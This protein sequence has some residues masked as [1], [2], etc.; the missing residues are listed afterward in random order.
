[1]TPDGK[2]LTRLVQSRTEKRTPII[3]SSSSSIMAAR[4]HYLEQETLN[5]L[6]SSSSSKINPSAAWDNVFGLTPTPNTP[7]RGRK[8]NEE[9]KDH[10]YSRRTTTVCNLFGDDTDNDEDDLGQNTKDVLV[11]AIEKEAHEQT[12]NVLGQLMSLLEGDNAVKHGVSSSEM[13]L[14]S[15]LQRMEKE[16]AELC[17]S[18]KLLKEKKID[19]TSLLL[20]R[21]T[22]QRNKMMI[23]MRK[24]KL[25][26][27]IHARDIAVA[28]WLQQSFA[29]LES[30]LKLERLKAVNRVS[31]YAVCPPPSSSLLLL[32]IPFF[33]FFFFF[34]F[35]LLLLP[36]GLLYCEYSL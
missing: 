31:I 21:I 14:T 34:F 16:T 19:M 32:P 4:R 8:E 11:C 3:I 12:S 18:T 23:A 29:T 7:F 5:R 13:S 1:M 33:F 17:R 30:S 6:L 25:N 15:R 36:T 2:E 26:E 35:L 28:E 10:L 22:E 27:D 9:N 20:S 24:I